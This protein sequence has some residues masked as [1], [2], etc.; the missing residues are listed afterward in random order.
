[1][2]LR[3]LRYFVLLGEELHFTRAA[4][5][6]PITQPAF[7]REIQRLERSVGVRLVDRGRQVALTPAGNRLL[8]HARRLLEDAQAA[9]DSTRAMSDRSRGTLRV[10][11]FANA[12]AE[13]TKPILLAYRQARPL[14]ELEVRSFGFADQISGVVDGEVDLM[15]CRPPYDDDDR[16]R[17][18]PLAVEPRVAVLPS[19]HAL[20]ER[21]SVSAEDLLDEPFIV[22]GAGAPATWR[23]YWSLVPE[24]GGAPRSARSIHDLSQMLQVI[25][26]EGHVST[27]AASIARYF[28]HPDVCYRPFTGAGGS[29]I[30]IATRSKASAD[31]A[32]DAF[33]TVACQVT[34]R[35]YGLVDGAS[36]AA[37][38]GAAPSR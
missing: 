1:V 38:A 8:I 3:Q 5:R 19:G 33:L 13:L 34:H 25:A 2:E 18:H 15:L 20:A 29:A 7:S 24:R 4:A 36:P 12:A 10:G 31:D 21:P 27:T 22:A 30:G 14:V 35:L 28:P 16:I 37:L 17:M 26:Y 32:A 11:L 9:Y 23:D 6:V